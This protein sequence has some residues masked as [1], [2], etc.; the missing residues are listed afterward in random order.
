MKPAII[1]AASVAACATATIAIPFLLYMFA[2]ATLTRLF[3]NYEVKKAGLVRKYATVQGLRLSYLEGGNPGARALLIIHGFTS[4]AEHWAEFISILNAK[5]QWPARII[6]V[7]LP[8]HGESETVENPEECGVKFMVE[9]VH[10]LAEQLNLEA[11]GPY[12]VMGL[13]LGG[14]VAGVYAA[15]YSS[16]IATTSL[17]CPGGTDAGE[18]HGIIALKKQHD[19]DILFYRN[20]EE[21]DEMFRFVM[22]KPLVIPY[23]IKEVL[24]ADS[25]RRRPVYAN[26]INRITAPDEAL[27]LH[28]HAHAIE[29]PTMVVW[30][31]K[32][33]VLSPKAAPILQSL[34]PN[35]T[36][37]HI[38][39]D[40]GHSIHNE[41]PVAL[42]ELFDDF[43]SKYGQ[44]RNPNKAGATESTP[45]LS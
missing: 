44:D 22:E 42:A 11:A 41:Q 2:P 26:I 30:G 15:T 35:C 29:A 37:M 10:G 12:N 21:L 4:R 43:I 8:C 24:V 16:E 39:K 36:T 45:L 28:M 23:R 25:L 27:L 3:V 17:L 7:D 38:M 31:E 19:R 34:I 18:D 13:S 33:Q 9:M 40:T 6:V 32:D 20:V 5:R 14:C 1:V